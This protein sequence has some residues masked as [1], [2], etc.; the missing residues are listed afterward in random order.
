MA[1]W[2]SIEFKFDLFDPLK[3][4]LEIL[5]QSLEIVEAVLE[6]LLDLIKPFLLDLFNPLNALIAALL[7]AL[8]AIINQIESSGLALLFVHPDFGA[9]DF[10]ATLNSVSGGYQAFEQ[11]VVGKFYDQAD[12]FRPLYPEGSSIAMLILYIGVESA[13]NLMSLIMAIMTLFKQGIDMSLP[14]PVDVKVTPVNQAGNAAAAFRQLFDG[15]YKEVLSVQWRMPE[16]PQGRD[17]AGAVNQAVSLFNS[18]R[19]PNFIIE[20]I[21]PFPNA[22]TTD[23]NGET[24]LISVESANIGKKVDALVERYNLPKVRSKVSVKE[25][26]GTVFRIFP[27]KYDVSTS[28][29]IGG[30]A[31]V[32]GAIT[33]SY[34]YEDEENLL[35]GKTYYY[36]VRAYFGDP[37]PYLNIKSSD[38]VQRGR[39]FLKEEGN[40]VFIDFSSYSEKLMLG[41]PSAVVGGFVPQETNKSDFDPY[42]DMMDAIRTGLLLNFELPASYPEDSGLEESSTRTAQKAGWGVLAALAGQIGQLKLAFPLSYDLQDNVLF[43]ARCRRFIN[44]T[45]SNIQYQPQLLSTLEDKWKGGVESI[46]AKFYK[47]GTGTF[48]ND[49]VET[50]PDGTNRYWVFE[51]VVGGWTNNN[52]KRIDEW[53][54]KEAEYIPGLLAWSGPVPV[55][56]DVGEPYVTLQERLDLAAFLQIAVGAVGVSTSYLAWQSVTVGD[57]FPALTP[58]LFD[59]EQFLLAMLQAVNS[60]LQNI[61]DLIQTILQ[62]VRALKQILETVLNILDILSIEFTASVLTYSGSGS[63]STLV[64]ALSESEDKPGGLAGGTPAGATPLNIPSGFHSGLVFTAGGPGPAFVAALEAIKFI[65]T[66]G[67]GE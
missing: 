18:F 21:G 50:V 1:K 54:A 5:L 61:A 12:L 36:R 51:P 41:K 35:P 42:L 62:K 46:V 27:T 16:A 7:A 58:F 66:L 23:P 6:A 30:E 19:M 60:A 38:D 37:T 28:V 20:R 59:F 26:D 53:L 43:N 24:A 29:T 32:E 13:G 17:L 49:P 55:R 25:R 52:A 11:K 63:V 3:P 57:L 44:L 10:G 15:D 48:S 65:F 4:P 47:R 8:R 34:E 64:Q 14:A 39:P 31:L 2:Q 22:Q 40:N 67:A 45:L 9:G 56:E 33:G